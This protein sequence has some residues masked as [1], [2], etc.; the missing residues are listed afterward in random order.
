LSTDHRRQITSTRTLTYAVDFE[1]EQG[2][3]S[4]R[5]GLGQRNQV[6]LGRR[7]LG[8]CVLGIERGHR[9]ASRAVEFARA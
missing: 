2:A 6:L 1:D 4:R 3:V 9:C 8:M 7:R 5:I